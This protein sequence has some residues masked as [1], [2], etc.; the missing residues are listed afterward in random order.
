[1]SPVALEREIAALGHVIVEFVREVIGKGDVLRLVFHPASVMVSDALLEEDQFVQCV[2]TALQVTSSPQLIV[3]RDGH[4]DCLWRAVAFHEHLV[5]SI[6]DISPSKVAHWMAPSC[7]ETIL[8]ITV[9]LSIEVR[10]NSC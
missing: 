7:V 8:D 1:M 4:Q 2:R 9:P 10:P 3:G 6:H 5:A